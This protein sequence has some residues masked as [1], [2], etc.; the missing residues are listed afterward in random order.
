MSAGQDEAN[1]GLQDLMAPFD[2]TGMYDSSQPGNGLLFACCV[3]CDCEKA[4]L[5]FVKS[6]VKRQPG[7]GALMGDLRCECHEKLGGGLSRNCRPESFDCIFD[8]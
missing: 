3:S 4:K 7:G 1:D 8:L 5:P 6:K 2:R